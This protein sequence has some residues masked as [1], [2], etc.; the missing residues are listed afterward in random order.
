MEGREEAK[1][2][3]EVY[4][5]GLGACQFQEGGEGENG[6]RRDGAEGP[7][8]LE[9]RRETHLPVAD[10]AV[11]RSRQIN[12]T[13]KRKDDVLFSVIARWRNRHFGANLFRASTFLRQALYSVG[14]K[15]QIHATFLLFQ[16]PIKAIAS[17]SSAEDKPF[18]DVHGCPHN[19]PRGRQDR[20]AQ[21]KEDSAKVTHA[22]VRAAIG[23][24]HVRLSIISFLSP[25]THHPRRLSVCLPVC[26]SPFLAGNGRMGTLV[27][28]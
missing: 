1:R 13:I 2:V 10:A 7:R 23:D 27:M 25:G 4:G 18:W 16:V 12:P 9:G 17:L 26:L 3:S 11:G 20:V 19:C 5:I 8:T 6:R 22:R 28:G 15:T 24:P 14:K 21:T